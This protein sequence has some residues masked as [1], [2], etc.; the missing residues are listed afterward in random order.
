MQLSD[1][2]C[3]SERKE[4]DVLRMNGDEENKGL[5]IGWGQCYC[6]GVADE[7]V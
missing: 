6:M 5:M 3:R 1:D 7:A 4:Y 2:K